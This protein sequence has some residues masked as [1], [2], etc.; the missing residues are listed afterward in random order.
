VTE[1]A[2]ARLRHAAETLIRQGTVGE[3]LV[4]ERGRV[5]DPVPVLGPDGEVHSYAVGVVVGEKLAGLLQFL[6]DGT[7]MRFASFERGRGS[8]EEAPDAADWL[9]PQRI[10]ARAEAHLRPHESTR[11]PYLTFEANPTRL[12]WLVPVVSPSGAERQLLVAGTSV[13]EPSGGGIGGAGPQ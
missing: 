12:A 5:R 6:P 8:V 10:R 3:G 13:F 11:T 4:R 9:D 7:L 1:T 2:R